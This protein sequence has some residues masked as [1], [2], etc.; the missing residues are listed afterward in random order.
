MSST[1][2]S[3]STTKSQRDIT[4][5]TTSDCNDE[6]FESTEE[7]YVEDSF[8]TST[9][10]SNNINDDANTSN[11]QTRTSKNY[12]LTSTTNHTMISNVEVNSNHDS[13]IKNNTIMSSMNTP[14]ISTPNNLRSRPQLPN[15]ITALPHNQF[16]QNDPSLEG[17][18]TQKMPQRHLSDPVILQQSPFPISQRHLSDPMVLQQSPFPM[19]QILQQRSN[20]IPSAI[21]A[22]QPVYILQSPI[23]LVPLTNQIYSPPTKIDRIKDPNGKLISSEKN[24]QKITKKILKNPNSPIAQQIGTSPPMSPS[25]QGIPQSPI[26]PVMARYSVIQQIPAHPQPLHPQTPGINYPLFLNN[27][28]SPPVPIVKKEGL[29]ST[30]TPANKD[31]KDDESGQETEQESGPSPMEKPRWHQ[32]LSWIIICFLNLVNLVA[33]MILLY[34]YFTNPSLKTQFSRY[35]FLCLFLIELGARIIITYR[36]HN[37]FTKNELTP[38][39]VICCTLFKK[40]F[41]LL[42]GKTNL[43]PSQIRNLSNLGDYT[44]FFHIIFF[45]Y[46]FI[47]NYGHSN[48]DNSEPK[49]PFLVNDLITIL[50]YVLLSVVCLLALRLFLQPIF[51]IFTKCGVNNADVNNAETMTAA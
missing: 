43:K 31:K 50:S 28:T 24:T 47:T 8:S 23:Q 1:L 22:T 9:S 40:E 4:T 34:I 19:S 11:N 17:H 38:T 42:V 27:N 48:D 29:P 46:A 49:V 18:A 20:S 35:A 7:H 51:S 44:C 26:S 15:I 14:Q 16:Y 25:L 2:A 45:V 6:G 41:F 10:K 21:P 39:D 5:A 36:I 37:K 33:S 13:Q 32:R 12:P 30:S 3:P